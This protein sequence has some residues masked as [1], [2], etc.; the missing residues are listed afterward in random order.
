MV[1]NERIAR[2]SN[3][4][5]D[6]SPRVY[7]TTGTPS[8]ITGG[9]DLKHHPEEEQAT[10]G[11]TTRRDTV[12]GQRVERGVDP[13]MDRTSAILGSTPSSE[14]EQ[15]I[16]KPMFSEGI[17]PQEEA[18]LINAAKEVGVVFPTAGYELRELY[19]H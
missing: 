17:S 13:L 1:D 8:P 2:R 7:D 6:R 5:V 4:A 9:L 12:V 14:T 19:L 11:S 16:S 15:H 18:F 3:E 10:S